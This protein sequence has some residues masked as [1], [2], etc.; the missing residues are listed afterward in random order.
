M[1]D[2]LRGSM[3]AAEYKHVVLGLIFLKHLS[4]VL[5]EMRACLNNEQTQE[6]DPED[7]NAYH[8]ENAFRVPAEARWTRLKAQ[9][10]QPNIGQ[11]VDAAMASVERDNP[12]LRDALPK[13]YANFAWIQHM[14]H[15]LAPGGTAGFVLANDS[16]S[17]SHAAESLIRKNLIE[18]DF[19]DCMV[20]LPGQLFYSTQLPICL[21]FLKRGKDNDE[22]GGRTEQILFI[23]ARKLGR[24]VNRTHRELTDEDIA[25]VSNTYHDWPKPLRRATPIYLASARAWRWTKCASTIMY[26]RSDVTSIWNPNRKTENL[27][28][29]R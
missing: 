14:V 25:S 1:A 20:A 5:E 3:D 2:E 24:M 11:I 10:R 15:H 6:A 21:W 23:D 27:L 17:S 16:M 22:R 12:D 9:A 29:R 4:D 8:A 7:P 19:V 18:A 26:S 28:K 13:G